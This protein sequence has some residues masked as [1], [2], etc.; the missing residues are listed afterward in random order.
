MRSFLGLALLLPA[1]ATAAAAAA[2]TTAGQRR[3]GW[4]WDAPASADDPTVDALLKWTANHTDIVSSVLMRCGPTTL[5]GSVSGALLP[6]CAKAIL[7]LKALGVES[8]L[9]LGETDSYESAL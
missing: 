7:A 6:S 3:I 2:G 8:E 4:W 9:W 5:N 1:A